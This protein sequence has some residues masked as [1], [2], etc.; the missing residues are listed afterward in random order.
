[1]DRKTDMEIQQRDIQTF[2]K[3]HKDRK[4]K[5]KAFVTSP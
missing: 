2:E 3:R 5:V 1:M 4:K